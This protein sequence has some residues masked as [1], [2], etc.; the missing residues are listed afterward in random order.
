MA[1]SCAIAADPPADFPALGQKFDSATRPLVQKYCLGCH[2]TEK[3]EGDLDLER[4]ATLEN[5]RKEPELW[6]HVSEQIVSG[7][8]PPKNRPRPTDAE[9]AQILGWIRDYLRAEALSAAGDPGNVLLRRLT[10]VEYDNTIRD[11]TG[12][13]YDATREFPVDG[14]AGEGF[15][16]VGEALA[17][18]PALLEKYLEASRKIASHIV[19]L[20][21]GLKF[22]ASDTPADWTNEYLEAIRAFYRARTE[23]AGHTRVKLHGLEW[24]TNAGGRLPL[25]AYLDAAAELAKTG[26]S[27]E[28]AVRDLAAQRKLSP[29]YLEIVRRFFA[30][31]SDDPIV[32]RLQNRFRELGPEGTAGLAADIQRWQMALTRFGSVGHFKPWLQTADPVVRVVNVREKLTAPP[33]GKPVR[34]KLSALPLG[35]FS[36]EARVVWRSPRLE[37]PGTSNIPVAG[38]KDAVA[39]AEFLRKEL[40]RTQAYLDV[41]DRV[42]SESWR[43]GRVSWKDEAARCGLDAELLAAW[44]GLAGI[45]AEP[46]DE[47]TLM[48]DRI[49]RSG[50]YDFVKGW[51]KDATPVAVANSSDQDVRVPGFMKARSVAVHPSPKTSVVVAWRSPIDGKIRIEASAVDIHGDCGNGVTWS[52][53]HRRGALRKTLAAGIAETSAPNRI[54]FIEELAVRAGQV[55]ALAIGPRDGDHSCD[56]TGVELNVTEVGDEGRFWNLREDVVPNIHAG[57]PH[58]DRFGEA[59]VWSFHEEPVG[60]ASEAP[61][62]IP[63]DSVLARW[64]EAVDAEPAVKKELAA[65]VGRIFSPDSADKS[66]TNLSTRDSLKSLDGPLL[67]AI[68]FVTAAAKTAGSDMIAAPGQPLTI[69]IPAEWAASRTFVTDVAAGARWG[70]SSAVQ[71][72]VGHDDSA[73]LASFSETRPVLTASDAADAFWKRSFERFRSVF[74]AALCYPQIVPV[75]EV[76]TLALFHREDDHLIRLMLDDSEK[77]ELDT[78]WHALRFV[79]QEPLKVE[80]GYKQFMEYVTQDGDVRLFEPLRKPIRERAADFRKELL[81]AETGQWNALLTTAD[82][83]WR[84]PL[85]ASEKA[86]LRALYDKLRATGTPHDQSIRLV[87]S[88]VLLA[89]AFLYLTEPSESKER[90]RPLTQHE[91]ATRL[92]YF[93]WSSMPDADLRKA[94]DEG[95]LHDPAVL[96]AQIRRMTAD[97]KA[98]A[99]ATEFACQWLNLKNFD[100]HDEKSER[101]FPE[102]AELRGPMY[103]EVVRFLT[104]VIRSNKPVLSILDSDRSFLNGTL[105]GFYGVEG[106]E[107]DAWREVGGMKKVG[108]GGLLGFAALTAKQSGAS[109]TSP[110]LRGNWLLESLLGEKLPKPPKNV[111]QLPE[112]ELDTEGLTMRQITEKHRA[113]PACAKCHDRIDHYGMAMEAFDAIG[114]RRK[115]DLGGR[116][117]D[118]SVALP[119]GTKFADVSGLRDYL[120]ATRRDQ[121]QRQFFRKLIGYALGR[122]VAVSD[123]P[124]IDS[125]TNQAQKPDFGVVDAIEAIV[126]SPQFLNRRGLTESVEAE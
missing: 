79:S 12:F 122:S 118:T 94:A 54:P 107:G 111:P 78:L 109:R 116:P 80:V 7:E 28:A 16:N 31:T 35:E 32:S 22:S 91:L 15:S 56:L 21:D 47:K 93:L 45:G 25:T 1:E 69:E 98:R 60:T 119:D 70:E 48:K 123:D 13:D 19:L 88:R 99:L 84:R 10:N 8:M 102:F 120:L 105:A 100:R 11:L 58:A 4:F 46:L 103:E 61:G 42:R 55:I 125:L 57:N 83:A 117:I 5:V 113:D 65:N 64:I 24:D 23:P 75:D 86:T 17:M 27:D 6:R 92:S 44:G 51:G 2:S 89:P 76:V 67:R 82:R 71:V 20:P 29:K 40:E 14:A 34:L 30:E 26:K 72:A 110:I 95:R 68:D 114:R 126:T 85:D 43:P 59:A 39:R 63:K 66:E 9:R 41:I 108:R 81:N 38:L 37:R 3:V 96:K 18:S 124:L 106:V 90:V 62:S 87:F 77:A 74:P 52:L 104:D 36:E 115:A 49:E 50:T 101:I 73:S 53:E 97:P 112:S 33:G 121:F